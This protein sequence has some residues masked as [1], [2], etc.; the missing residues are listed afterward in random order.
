M[1]DGVDVRVLLAT[2]GRPEESGIC[3][4]RE[5]ENHAKA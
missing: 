4:K 3:K 1:R 2:S 5:R